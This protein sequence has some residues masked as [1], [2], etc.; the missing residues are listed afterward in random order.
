VRSLTVPPWASEA[1]L[2]ANGRW[3]ALVSKPD[4]HARLTHFQVRDTELAGT[5]RDVELPGAFEFD[6]LSGDGQ[7]LFL[8][9]HRPDGSD[10]VKLYDLAAQRLLPD[11][12]ADKSDGSTV[13]SGA[14][15][16]G[17]ATADG[18]EQLTL[19]ERDARNQ[20]FV[21]VLPVGTATQFAY[22]VDLPAPGSNWTLTPSPDGRRFYAVN[23]VSESVVVLATE[24]LAP[25]QVS[26]GR[27]DA[28]SSRFGLVRDAEAKEAGQRTAAALSAD[29]ATLFAGAGSSVVRVDAATLR[30]GAIARLGGEEVASLAAARS[31]WLYATTVAGRV[32]RIDPGSMRVAL[33]SSPSFDGSSIVRAV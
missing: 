4:P 2:S 11:A 24:G 21:H 7:R 23:M 22:C 16:N 32:L 10:L 17:F 5:P 18:Q 1:R 20:S 13:M 9:Q 3:L 25:P 19:Y 30:A 12:I 31:G 8:L 33:T 27:L 14:S 28:G 6:G 26:S 29:G 15:V